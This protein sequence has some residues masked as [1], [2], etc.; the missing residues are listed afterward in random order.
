MKDLAKKQKWYLGSVEL[1]LKI[2]D[3][4]T[5]SQAWGLYIKWS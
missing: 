5:F 2:K 1:G 4:R 3:F